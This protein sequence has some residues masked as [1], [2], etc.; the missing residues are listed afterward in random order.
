MERHSGSTL[1]DLLETAVSRW[2]DRPLLLDET[3]ALC[4]REFQLRVHGL[5]CAFSSR[6]VTAGD[7]VAVILPNCPEILYIWF[8][9]AR[10]GAVLMPVNPALTDVEIAPLL[11]QLGARALIADAQRLA[12]LHGAID[13]RLWIAAGPGSEL[14]ALLQPVPDSPRL[15]A[16]PAAETC[17]L[18]TSGTTERAKSAAL[19]HQSYLLPAQEFGQ[20]MEVTPGD[21]FL[22]CLPLF[23]LAGQS[24]AIS[25]VAAGA[26]LAVVPRF[27][28]RR[29]WTQVRRHRITLVRH[30]GEMLA[31]LCRQP[32]EAADRD[33]SLRAVYGGGARIEV[34]DEFERRFNVPVIEGYGLTETNTVLRNELRSRRRGSIGR[35]L[36]YCEVRIAGAAGETLLPAAAGASPVGEIQ[37]RRNP[38]MMSGYAGATE[39]TVAAFTGEWL[40][41]G[42]LGYLDTEGW[43]YFVSRSKDLIRR[44]GENLVAADIEKVLDGHPAVAQ[45]AV[46]G[47]ADEVG[48][49]EAKATVAL[50]PG[51][52]L[53]PEELVRWCRASL[54]EFEVPRYFELCDDLP[55]T[56]T[57][58]IHKAKLRTTSLA[59][60]YDR[61]AQRQTVTPPPADHREAARPLAAAGDVA[62]LV[63][64]VLQARRALAGVALHTP[65]LCSERLDG[66]AGCQLFFKAECL[67]RTGSFKL[68]GAYNCVRSLSA[69]DRQRGLITVSTGN[70]AV[71]AAY[72]ARVM[73]ASLVVVMPGTALPEKLTLVAQL[74]AR[75]ESRGITN[76]AEAFARVA[77][78]RREHGY[79]L[80]HPFDDPFVV[81]GAATAVWELLEEVPDLDLL[82]VPASGGGLLGGG[83]L[84]AQALAP[85]VRVYGVQPQG[86]DGIVRSLAAGAPTAPDRI[87]TVADGLTV[88]RPG[89]LNFDL[90]RRYCAGILTAS[91][92]AILEA[93]GRIVRELRVVVEPAGAAGLAAALGHEQCRGRRVGVLLSGGN[94]SA[95]R[96]R[97]VLA[98]TAAPPR[99]ARRETR[100]RA[101]V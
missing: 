43:F 75:V 59:A 68:R 88:P 83:L 3:G 93:M 48:G 28:A 20:W 51:C 101:M 78:L 89:C 26:A 80:V 10:L 87:D 82:L 50:R 4:Y 96:L 60:C 66:F 32:A 5:T 76:S 97:Q 69:A 49:E 36:P 53:E 38:V 55:R 67:Q 64:K 16:D 27:S 81:A 47:V 70:A 19:S 100:R 12:S 39:L 52:R 1:P 41:T 44:R 92:G 85:E 90:I 15:A 79:T 62:G 94:V 31:V 73:G 45:S 58:K 14:A 46:V 86:A 65:V 9:L 2:G 18:R 13:P 56:D 95:Q 61:S 24:F 57:H 29:F 84:A 21:R 72:A 40:K 30:L 25:A 35:T 7:R 71:G 74:G 34:A 33:H 63:A 77:E 17:L 23:H 6:G 11:R 8:A 91:D 22:A 37:V 98:A 54:A 99:C 42:D